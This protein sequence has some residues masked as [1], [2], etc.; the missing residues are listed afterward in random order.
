MYWEQNLKNHQRRLEFTTWPA[1]FVLSLSFWLTWSSCFCRHLCIQKAKAANMHFSWASGGN[2]PC[3]GTGEVYYFSFQEECGGCSSCDSSE[4]RRTTA[5]SSLQRTFHSV[6]R[7]WDI[8]T[9]TSAIVLHEITCSYLRKGKKTRTMENLSSP[10]HRL[11]TKGQH[12]ESGRACS[13]CSPLHVH[14]WWKSPKAAVGSWSTSK[15]M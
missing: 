6:W 2:E 9:P 12:V 3:F 8:P 1:S 14:R 15:L 10:N 11:K 7:S 13:P 4:V 5:T